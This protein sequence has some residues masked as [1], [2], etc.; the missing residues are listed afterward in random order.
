MT[1]AVKP[2]KSVKKGAGEKS[3]AGAQ[4]VQRR[5]IHVPRKDKG[6]SRRS[7]RGGREPE[8]GR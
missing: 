6:S 4:G 2:E 1:W 3:M 5:Q 7:S 8:W